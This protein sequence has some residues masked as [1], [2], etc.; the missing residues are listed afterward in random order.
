MIYPRSFENLKDSFEMLPG[1]GEK[2]AE[3]FIFSILDWDKEEVEELSNNL[4]SFKEHIVNCPIC[5][6]ICEDGYCSICND[7]TRD[8]SVICVVED[9]KKVFM[10][11]KT[12]SFNGLY[13]VLGGLISPIDDIN[14]EDINIS[15]LVKDRVT[16]DLKEIII[17]LNPSIEGE[18]TSLY[19]QKVLRDKNVGISRLSY[20]IPMGSDIEYIDPLVIE[21]AID[22]RKKI[23]Y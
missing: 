15:S 16:D 1:I 14:P 3:R 10:L 4:L 12:K 23:E 19:L 7:D 5:G 13:H 9:S 17:A 2:T 22:D 6:H 8:K 20:G 18:T 11:E 21:K